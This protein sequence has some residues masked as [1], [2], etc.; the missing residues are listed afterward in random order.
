MSHV[1]SDEE[2][3]DFLEIKVVKAPPLDYLQYESTNCL[4]LLALVD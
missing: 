2:D 3:R 1:Y 4:Q